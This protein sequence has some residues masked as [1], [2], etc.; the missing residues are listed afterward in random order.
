MIALYRW[1]DDLCYSSYDTGENEM[2]E[3]EAMTYGMVEGTVDG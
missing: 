3:V 1:I 2:D